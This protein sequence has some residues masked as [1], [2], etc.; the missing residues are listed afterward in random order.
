MIFLKG[1]T[2]IQKKSPMNQRPSATLPIEPGFRIEADHFVLTIVEGVGKWFYVRTATD[3]TLQMECPAG[4]DF[5]R[6]ELQQWIRKAI[7]ECMRKQAKIFLPPRL[8]QLARQHGL[9]FSSVKINC[10]HGRWGSCSGKGS[11]NLSCQLMLLPTH[12]ID[13]VLL[14]ELAHTREMNHG[15]GFWALL[16]QLTDG[17]AKALQ[18]EIRGYHT[19]R[20]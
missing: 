4:T 16:D 13:Y 1:R 5:T 10:S 18:Q 8:H 12:L 2:R 19:L 20:S 6:P 7:V 17:K 15:K 14:H 11:I 9:T 3:G